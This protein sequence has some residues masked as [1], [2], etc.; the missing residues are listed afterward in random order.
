MLWLLEAAARTSKELSKAKAALSPIG[1]VPVG[2]TEML[3]FSFK[4]LV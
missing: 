2:Q 3:W 4:M 1:E